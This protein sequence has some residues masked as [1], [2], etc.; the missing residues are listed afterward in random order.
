MDNKDQP[1][2]PIVSKEFIRPN[3]EYLGLTKREYFAI[4]ALQGILANPNR[5][6]NSDCSIVAL[7]YADGLLS[8]LNK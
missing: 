5:G 7:E 3:D 1:V 4:M 6:A 8:L 2:Y